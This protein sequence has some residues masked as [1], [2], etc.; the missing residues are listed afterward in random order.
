MQMQAVNDVGNLL[1][2]VFLITTAILTAVLAFRVFR[3]RPIR[4]LAVAISLCLMVYAATLVGV[5]L[6][7]ERR[8]LA[9]GTDKCFDDWCATVTGARFLP[10]VSGGANT[11][12]VAV[13]LRVSNRA[14][15]AA[16]RPSQPRVTLALGAG[17]M[18]SP[19]E[20]G[21]REFEKQ[22]GP[23]ETLAKRLVA[24]E[25]F[26]TTLAFEVP[27]A[28]HEASVLLLEG[29]AVITRFLVGDENSLL[30]RKTVYPITVE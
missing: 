23:Q 9:L 28:T 26:Q 15:Q 7:S 19:S 12:V 6:S 17:E 2:F 8:Q 18:I 30:H 11:K 27:S 5:S 13:S 16:F 22:A 3:G 1:F 4:K 20:S 14:R 10:A 29:P 24:G 21:Q 25:T